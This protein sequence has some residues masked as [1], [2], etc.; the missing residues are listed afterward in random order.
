PF[1]DTNVLSQL[2]RHTREAPR[3]LR[4]FSTDIPDA[5][6][7]IVDWM[8][9]KDPAQRYATPE[10][11]AQALQVFLASHL[12]EAASAEPDARMS[13]YLEWLEKETG[14][15]PGPRKVPAGVPGRSPDPPA[16]GP[17]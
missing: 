16:A 15:E 11:A 13:S 3:P 9:A 17:F 10:R 4:E 12:E 8:I 6:Q 5:L 1:P 7:Q 2:V 14:V